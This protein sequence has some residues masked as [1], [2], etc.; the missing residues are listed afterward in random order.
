VVITGPTEEAVQRALTLC[1]HAVFGEAQDTIDLRSRSIV[2]CVY[3]KD[4][5]KIRSFQDESGA[6]L[7]IEKGGS[8]L[9]ISGSKEAV[10]SARTLVGAWVS[11]CKGTTL[12]VEEGKVGA[13]FGKGGT[14]LRRIQERT[15]AF[16]DVTGTTLADGKRVFEICGEPDAVAEAI[17]LCQKAVSGEVELGPGEV[18]DRVELGAGTPAV[19]GRGG[20]RVAEL[21]KTHGVKILVESSSG[22]CNIVG[23]RAA[24]DKAKAAVL[25]VAKPLI[26]EAK[27]RE[28]ADRLATQSDSNLNAWVTVGEETGW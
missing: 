4:Y 19:I 26:E 23:K 5:A 22:G 10:A 12:E 2:M 16:V 25:A 20:S 6:K 14:N 3:G 9:K 11:Y 17:A 21:E 15:G 18:L 27:I 1:R 13:V 28:E 8:I 24:V 7:D